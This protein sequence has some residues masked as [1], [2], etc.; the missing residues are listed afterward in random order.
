MCKCTEKVCTSNYPTPTITGLLVLRLTTGAAQQRGMQSNK[1]D[2]S[3]WVT[4]RIISD[5][6][7]SP[8]LVVDAAS[9]QVVQQLDYDEFGRVQNDTSPG[10]QPFGFAEGLYEQSTGLVRFGARDYDTKTGRWT[11]KDPI[12]FAG[13]SSNIYCYGLSDPINSI[14]IFGLSDAGSAFQLGGLLISL[15]G[16][17]LDSGSL[18]TVGLAVTAVGMLFNYEDSKDAL[19]DF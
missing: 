16:V 10:F 9:G 7:G 8:R 6:L 3:T 2:G 1:A 11:S 13:K 17:L 4:Y 12:L 15:G 19:T 18:S 14:D 5:Q